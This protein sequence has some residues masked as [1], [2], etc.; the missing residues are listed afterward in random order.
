MIY[1]LFIT[2]LI[3]Y[4]LYNVKSVKYNHIENN[5]INHAP[6]LK[7]SLPVLNNININKI[8]EKDNTFENDGNPLKCVVTYPNTFNAYLNQCDFCPM[9]S[10]KQCSNNQYPKL[11]SPL[12]TDVVMNQM[13]YT[14]NITLSPTC[15]S[16][17]RDKANNLINY[18]SNFP[19]VNN[20][21]TIPTSTY[22]N[23][24]IYH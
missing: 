17:Y 10:F 8:Y 24:G 11:Y 15:I 12:V 14:P 2:L 19:R 9:S 18:P 3:I 21:M 23:T 20:W 16:N 1:I 13:S 22:I 6:L 4:C 7:K 5:V